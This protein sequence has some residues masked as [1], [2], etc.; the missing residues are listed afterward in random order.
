MDPDEWK[1]QGFT[2]EQLQEPEPVKYKKTGGR[3][4]GKGG[5]GILNKKWDEYTSWRSER[6]ANRQKLIDEQE[7]QSKIRRQRNRNWLFRQDRDVTWQ[8]PDYSPRALK[9]VK[10]RNLRTARKAFANLSSEDKLNLHL[11]DT[12]SNALNRASET[13]GDTT[14]RK[15]ETLV[16]KEIPHDPPDARGIVKNM[17]ES[18]HVLNQMGTNSLMQIKKAN[19]QAWNTLSDQSEVEVNKKRKEAIKKG[20]K[21]K[22][23]VDTKAK[24]KLS[25]LGKVHK[26]AGVVSDLATAIDPKSKPTRFMEE[27]DPDDDLWRV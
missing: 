22:T 25:T 2:Q 5:P 9:R 15:P 4:K 24:P 3:R 7:A 11:Q 26:W 18:D 21:D 27:F 20:E 17:Y 1:F 8:T 12:S 10:T 19:P 23:T 6:R 16:N 14:N 13:S